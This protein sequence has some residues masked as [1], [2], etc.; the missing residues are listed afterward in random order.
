MC[1]WM[2]A[3]V[4]RRN[5]SPNLKQEWCYRLRPPA[6]ACVPDPCASIHGF[7]QICLLTPSFTQ[8][9]SAHI[10]PKVT[11]LAL[12]KCFLLL[13]PAF[14]VIS[15]LWSLCEERWVT[16]TWLGARHVYFAITPPCI[17]RVICLSDVFTCS[18]VVALRSDAEMGCC[19][20]FNYWRGTRLFF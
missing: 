11:V 15:R 8:V 16:G 20:F 4:F 5:F 6:L 12:I 3:A 18:S 1:W 10:S 17:G 7:C 14:E 9:P 2:F 13:F 19:T